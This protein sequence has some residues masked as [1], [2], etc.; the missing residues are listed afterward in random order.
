MSGIK[1]GNIKFFVYTASGFLSGLTAL[2]IEFRVNMLNVSSTEMF[3]IASIAAVVIGGTSLKGGEGNVY[4]TLIGAFIMASIVNVMNLT[5]INVYSQNIVKGVVL[6]TFVTISFL[7]SNKS[8]Q[9][10]VD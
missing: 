9:G 6:L 4:G 3:Q 10:Y 8:K 7:L 1:T 5:G 2:T